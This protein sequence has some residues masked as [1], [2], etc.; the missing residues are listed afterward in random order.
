M[1]RQLI[2]ERLFQKVNGICHSHHSIFFHYDVGERQIQIV[3]YFLGFLHKLL[4][5]I[6]GSHILKFQRLPIPI[7]YLLLLP[8]T[9]L[10]RVLLLLRYLCVKI[11]IVKCNQCKGFK[12]IHDK[13]DPNKLNSS[14]RNISRW[15]N[16]NKINCNCCNIY[17][18]LKL[19]ERS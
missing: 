18:E 14:Q 7:L 1:Q 4:A 19:N 16:I 5:T 15:S 13:V 10:I 6:S 9:Y 3:H 8:P 17:R 12:S 2:K 11:T